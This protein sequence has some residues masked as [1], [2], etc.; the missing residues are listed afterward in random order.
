MGQRE[1]AARAPHPAPRA[2]RVVPVYSTLREG[3]VLILRGYTLRIGLVVSGVVGTIL[4]I[5]NQ[6]STLATGHESVVLWLR[7]A[8]NYAVPFLVSSI[9]Y[10]APAR[11]AREEFPDA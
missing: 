11:L 10:V 9:G 7:I 1:T 8:T 5:V 3:L 2:R 6:G 4:S